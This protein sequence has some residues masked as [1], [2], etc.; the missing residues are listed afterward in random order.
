MTA[1]PLRVSLRERAP[2]GR[3]LLSRIVGRARPRAALPAGG[4]R[5][6]RSVGEGTG[7]AAVTG[8]GAAQRSPRG[9]A[10]RAASGRVGTAR[11]LWLKVRPGPA[12]RLPRRARPRGVPQRSPGERPAGGLSPRAHRPARP[13]RWARRA[14]LGETLS[15]RLRLHLGA[16]AEMEGRA[17]PNPC[18]D[19]EAAAS[20]DAAA[21]AAAEDADDASRAPAPDEL[22]LAFHDDGQIIHLGPGDPDQL[23]D[24]LPQMGAGLRRGPTPLCLYWPDRPGPAVPA[25]APGAAWPD[26]PAAAPGLRERT[27][28]SPSGRRL[29]S[30]AGRGAAGRGSGGVHTR[31]DGESPE[32]VAKLLQLQRSVVCQ[33]PGLPDGLLYGGQGILR[34]PRPG[35]GDTGDPGAGSE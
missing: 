27:L 24:L 2:R 19:Y 14:A 15:K 20:A 4:S 28:R 17:F 10:A 30:L 21:S 13:R 26:P 31:S 22:G 32:C 16:E 9:P 25:A 12:Q 8:L 5:A 1:N 6:G 29:P 35:A 33:D 7:P 23:R 3:P 34:P 11:Q 18:P